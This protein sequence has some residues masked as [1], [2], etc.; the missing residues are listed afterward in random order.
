MDN[1]EHILAGID[2]FLDLLQAA[3][4]FSILVT[5]QAVL[6]LYGET[7]FPITPLDIPAEDGEIGA[8]LST[9]PAIALFNN[10]ARN[11]R[12]DFQQTTENLA[13]IAAICRYLDGLPLA[14]ELAAAQIRYLSPA[15]ILSRLQRN[16]AFLASRSRNIPS[17]HRTLQAAIQWSYDLLDETEKRLFIT[18]SIFA[19]SFTPA[20]V[21]AL[22]DEKN[23]EA[24]LPILQNLADKN[25]I[26]PAFQTAP[27]GEIRF[28]MLA[29]L[30][31]FAQPIIKNDP[32]Y[33]T[34]QHRYI[35]YFAQ[36]AHQAEIN[37][38]STDQLTWQKTLEI[39]KANM[40]SAL[41]WALESSDLIETGVQIIFDLL[42]YWETTLRSAEG[43]QWVKKAL[44]Q[45]GRLPPEK[46]S[47]LY[48]HAGHYHDSIGGDHK[49]TFRYF[50]QAIDEIN[51]EDNG[52]LMAAILNSYGAAAEHTGDHERSLALFKEAYALS[53][54]RKNPRPIDLAVLQQSI[55]LIEKELGHYDQAVA[56]LK[57]SRAVFQEHHIQVYEA[58]TLL[59][60][61]N[62][63]RLQAAYDQE[64]RHLRDGLELA[65]SL[66][67]RPARLVGL[68]A[69]ADSTLVHQNYVASAQLHSA[70]E[71]LSRQMDFPWSV[72]YES[73]FTRQVAQLRAQLGPGQFS[74]A[75]RRGS[76]L[77]LNEAVTLALESI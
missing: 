31:L 58:L 57:N 45:S 36:I 35:N 3:P 69:A 74:D 32:L 38:H 63:Y 14:I 5:S 41:T 18:L 27:A 23:E 50:D 72:D 8:D 75:W 67:Y 16:P 51:A 65:G 15:G 70:Y 20:G 42:H 55:A 9:A 60:L 46:V 2:Q 59:N 28:A 73:Q 19:D 48:F 39:E 47:R 4:G 43:F 11:V 66:E 24:T 12:A 44:T 10:A 56:R 30:R 17:R 77:K 25:I 64:R 49:I 33:P 7:V 71:G 61:S 53:L 1:A 26:Y 37:W 68:S 13:D 22:F 6:N 52:P 34:Y 76:L 54:A 29:T 40:R 62:V 21:A